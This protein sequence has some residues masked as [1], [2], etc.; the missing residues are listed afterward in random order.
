MADTLARILGPSN[1]GNGTTTLFTGTAAHTY[2]IKHIIVVNNT[3]GSITLRLGIGGVADSNLILKPTAIAAGEHTEFTGLLVMAG[4][5]TLQAIAT[6]TG[7]TI[8]IS[9]LDQT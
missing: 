4:T 5:E 1:I 6:A 3:A 2:T 8:T 9:G 7:M